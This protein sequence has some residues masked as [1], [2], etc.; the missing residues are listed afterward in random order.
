MIKDSNKEIGTIEY[1]H[2]NLP[3]LIEFSDSKWIKYTYDAAGI[4]LQ[5]E[6]KD[7]G[8][9]STLTDYAGSYVYQ[10]GSELLYVLTDL[11]RLVPKTGG[12]FDYEY[13][14]KDH[15]GNTRL[16]VGDKN[17]NNLL[18]ITD[19]MQET[20]YY[21]F[22]MA[23]GGQ[24]F[25]A[26]EVNKNKIKFQ[27][28]EEQDAFN[29]GWYHFRWRMHN[30]EIGRF[31]TIDPLSEKYTYNSPYAF[32]ENRVIDGVEIEGLEWCKTNNGMK[33]QAYIVN[34]SR[35]SNLILWNMKY[36]A[37]KE[38]KATFGND[39]SI[40][41]RVR[42]PDENIKIPEGWGV[43]V[44]TDPEKFDKLSTGGDTPLFGRMIRISANKIDEKGRFKVGPV[45]NS[46]LY[47]HEIG[48]EGGLEH[49]F[50][51]RSFGRKDEVQMEDVEFGNFMSYPS[52]DIQEYFQYY[53]NEKG[54]FPSD[55]QLYNMQ[56]WYHEI[57]QP[58]TEGQKNY[59]IEN[60]ENG[61][62]NQGDAEW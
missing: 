30:P 14:I 5:Q 19:I 59:I 29:L 40:D 3:K 8:S 17:N 35:S 32:S 13:F 57:G 37:I 21:P 10:N 28:Q 44:L 36:E 7:G 61:N 15:L 24:S 49:P 46:Y 38:F 33:Y 56:K 20:H 31:S 27:G 4:K 18:E 45:F 62:L 50:E 51:L 60:Y 55:M 12:G 47:T 2:L 52:K 16:V 25:D 23:L 9:T 53:Y 6:I 39:W 1:N 22:G 48:H 43:I 42:Y 11:G 58:A 41:L 34:D 26:T 54:I